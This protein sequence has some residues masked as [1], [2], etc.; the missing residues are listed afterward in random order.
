MLQRIRD[1]FFQ[2]R[3]RTVPALRDF[4][5]SQAS[6][7]AQRTSL[8]FSRNTLAYSHQYLIH[9]DAF[10]DALRVCRWESFGALVEDMLVLVEG[11]LRPDDAEGKRLVAEALTAMARAIL[12]RYE[13]PRHRP[14][15]WDDVIGR[16]AQRLAQ[17]QLGPPKAPLEISAVAG[18]RLYEVMPVFSDNKK[19][20]RELVANAVRFGFAGFAAKLSAALDGPAVRREM[21]AVPVS[22]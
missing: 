6:Y 11:H 21:L 12:E 18:A 9:D 13:R 1:Y 7:L 2:P 14:E 5:S 20:D 3:L 17:A 16:I 4:V 10:Q 8:E 15:G 19:K 22:A